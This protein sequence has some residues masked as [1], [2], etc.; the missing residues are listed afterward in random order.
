MKLNKSQREVLNKQFQ[1]SFNDV[2]L[3]EAFK[4]E[5]N[6]AYKQLGSEILQQEGFP[7]YVDVNNEDVFDVVIKPKSDMNVFVDYIEN[8]NLIESGEEFE[9]V[10]ND[11]EFFI[12]IILRNINQTKV[13]LKLKASPEE[14]L[15]K[16][17][18]ESYLARAMANGFSKSEIETRLKETSEFKE[19]VK[20][21]GVQEGF[22]ANTKFTN[23]DYKLDNVRPKLSYSSLA[24]RFLDGGYINESN[25]VKTFISNQFHPLLIQNRLVDYTI[26]IT[27][28][29][30]EE[31]EE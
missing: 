19:E 8:N 3:E 13:D 6:T 16:A 17:P 15:E 26:V 23:K 2:M 30:H 9:A 21:A 25:T 24:E 7:K 28:D 4:R 29:P 5:Y 12:D 31:D 14:F 18:T 22:N 1:A 20:Q 11:A 27:R 10:R